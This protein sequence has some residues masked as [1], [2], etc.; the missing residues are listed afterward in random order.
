MELDI[1]GFTTKDDFKDILGLNPIEDN[2]INKLK[3][4]KQS[5]IDE[6]K[7]LQLTLQ[8]IKTHKSEL[9][10]LLS[11]VEQLNIDQQINEIKELINEIKEP[12]NE[13]KEKCKA[14]VKTTN[15]P[16]NNNVKEN[17]YCGI[18]HYTYEN[19]SEFIKKEIIYE[20]NEN[21]CQALVAKTKIPCTYKV[22]EFSITG[23]Y[24]GR[25]LKRE[26]NSENSQ[27][28][29]KNTK[30]EKK[31]KPS[32]DDNEDEDEEKQT[33]TLKVKKDSFGR[34]IDENTKLVFNDNKLVIG[35]GADNGTLISLT[36]D[37]LKMCKKLN[38]KV[39]EKSKNYNKVNNINKFE[40]QDEKC[41]AIVKTTNLP[42]N[43]KAKENGYCGIHNEKQNE[44]CKSLVKTTNLPCNN[45]AKENGY[46][47]I[48]NHNIE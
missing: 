13:I 19:K 33:V 24:C 22:S 14:I 15:L 8:E 18:H 41:K 30:K 45:K 21:I 5:I 48:H 35:K 17:G 26:N 42:C 4:L 40:K 37:D 28:K 29:V 1:L 27:T 2:K 38:F 31:N 23:K 11:K 16:C 7:K 12:I 6:E 25:H 43:N 39:K 10:E 44:K 9:L 34:W 46:C 32:K 36:T 47:G 20:E 3:I